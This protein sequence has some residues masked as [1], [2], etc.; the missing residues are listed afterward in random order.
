[1]TQLVENI[2]EACIEQVTGR[3]IDMRGWGQ[4]AHSIC[5]AMPCLDPAM[6]G[7]GKAG[8]KNARLPLFGNRTGAR[9]IC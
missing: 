9:V 5:P 7:R 4:A 8:C 6:F 3:S 1:M 2:Y